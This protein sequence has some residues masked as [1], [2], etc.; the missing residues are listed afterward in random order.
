MSAFRLRLVLSAILAAQTPSAEAGA[1]VAPEVAPDWAY[2]WLHLA[3]AS[4]PKTL[5][6]V[7]PPISHEDLE[8]YEEILHLSDAQRLYLQKFHEDYLV[9]CWHLERERIPDA[10][11]LVRSMPSNS[12]PMY[13][14]RLQSWREFQYALGD[15]IVAEDDRLFLAMEIALSDEQREDMARVRSQRLRARSTTSWRGL[16]ES[17]LD[18]SKLSR[19]LPIAARIPLESLMPEYEARLTPLLVNADR[20][21][22]EG[23]LRRQRLVHEMR[24]DDHGRPIDNSAAG[25]LE[26][27]QKIAEQR[28][29]TYA[30]DAR[31]QRRLVEVNRQFLPRVLG[32]LDSADAR[33][34][35]D[36]YRERAFARVYPDR[37]DPEMIYLDVAHDDFLADAFRPTV[38]AIWTHYRRQYEAKCA[39]ME[40]ETRRWQEQLIGPIPRH[41]AAPHNALMVD[42][43]QHRDDLSDQFVDLLFKSIP[44]EFADRKQQIVDRW[45]AGLDQSREE[46]RKQRVSDAVDMR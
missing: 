23:S 1:Q 41:L 45:R 13:F 37:N 39:E 2:P 7:P 10:K 25:A 36:L 8:W 22:R 6:F 11:A 46:R 21:F 15:R 12:S 43:A 35:Q 33:V 38:E 5:Q 16:S 28:A 18:L 42:L 4:V 31:C 34:L 29:A 27:F 30:A 14:E 32:A 44:P 26:R 3:N 24:F 9:R 17:T 20:C 19:L 40:D